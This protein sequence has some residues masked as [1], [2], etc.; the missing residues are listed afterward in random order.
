[1]RSTAFPP[2]QVV[3]RSFEG[4]GNKIDQSHLDGRLREGIAADSP[5]H[6]FGQTS[7]RAG[8]F[9]DEERRDVAVDDRLDGLGG[10]VAP[11]RTADGRGFAET[12]HAV[13]GRD[14]DDRVVLLGD[15]REGQLVR[16]HGRHVDQRD[17][18]GGDLDHGHA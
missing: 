14:L 5:V 8:V 6:A 12:D 1:M 2:R 3:S 18:D 10:L 17:G 9:A 16:T 4:A 11:G 13:L 7:E 15:G